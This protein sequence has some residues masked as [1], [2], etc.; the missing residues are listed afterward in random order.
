MGRDDVPLLSVFLAMEM[1]LDKPHDDDDD[2]L[3]SFE[4]VS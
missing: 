3:F 4:D 1:S 2:D